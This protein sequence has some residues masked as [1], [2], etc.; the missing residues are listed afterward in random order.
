VQ[1]GSGM[2]GIAEKVTDVIARMGYTMLPPKNAAGF[3][4]V[5]ATSIFA[6]PDALADAGRL[7][8]V[9]KRGTVVKQETLPAGR[10]VV[11]VGKD[12]PAES[13]PK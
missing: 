9:L 13:L 10:I 4:D 6:A 2:V 1:N 7:R 3:P 12:L 8:G 11:L 5:A